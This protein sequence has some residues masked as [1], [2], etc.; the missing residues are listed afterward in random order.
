MNT[1]PT[2]QNNKISENEKNWLRGLK[3]ELIISGQDPKQR[4]IAEEERIAKAGVCGWLDALTIIFLIGG[5]VIAV[6]IAAALNSPGMGIGIGLASIVSSTV[7]MAL[8]AIIMELRYI[9]LDIGARK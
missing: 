5:L 1:E 9:R 2:N 6:V 7:F 4:D 3:N 8:R